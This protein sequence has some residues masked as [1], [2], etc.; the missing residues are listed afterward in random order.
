M[1]TTFNA[2]TAETAEKH[3]DSPRG[4]LC[5]LGDLCGS[6]NRQLPSRQRQPSPGATNLRMLWM[7]WALYSTPS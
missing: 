4:F 2:E 3:W 6:R 7:A 1:T 5:V